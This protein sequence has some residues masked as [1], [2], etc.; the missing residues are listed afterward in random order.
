MILPTKS[1]AAAFLLS[2][3]PGLG[4]L[5]LHRPVRA[6]LYACGFFG[7]LALIFIMVISR[8]RFP[9][10]LLVFL[11]VVAL[12]TGFGN[13]LDMVITLLKRKGERGLPDREH[14]GAF[15]L[16]TEPTN[17]KE[18]FY[19]ILLSFVP[20]LG[21]FQLGLMQRG[22]VLLVGFFGTFVMIVFVSSLLNAERFLVFLGILPV[23]WF[24]SMFDAL[25]QLTRKQNGETL[26]DRSVFDDFHD[27]RETGRK[28]KML[29]T[30]L[31]VFPGAGH[32][33][34]GLQK[35]GIQLMAAFLFSI[36]ILD[37][38]RLSIFLFLIPIIWFFSMFDALQNISKQDTEPLKDTPFVE[39][40]I[41]HQKWVGFA[42]L[43][44]GAYYLF[45]QVVV[46]LLERIWPDLN[47]SFWFQKYLQ[48][49]IVSVL[50]IGGG[51]RLLLGSK[52]KEG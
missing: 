48:T 9:D 29:A 28:S 22:L 33:Y 40:I 17:D 38:L 34:L 3:I 20:G 46:S 13:M 42:L 23:I 44:L 41:H 19:T 2:F 4:H 5:Y 11:L 6:F 10:E 43:G 32:M 25:Q 30:I 8:S 52:R 1:S 51:I 16:S 36:Y 27:S 18:R 15:M 7:P 49:A 50:L 31:S 47:L 39:W 45:D 21:H 24:Y 26:V 35:R 37:V 14:P 12:L